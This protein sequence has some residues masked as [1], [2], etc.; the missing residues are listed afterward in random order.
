MSAINQTNKTLL[1]ESINPERINLLTL[2]GEVKDADSLSDEKIREI[3]SELEVSSFD[4]CIE[5]FVPMVYACYNANSQKILYSLTRP[6]NVPEHMLTEIPL[7]KHQD[8]MKMLLTLLETK[9]SAGMLNVD[10]KFEDLLK[11]ITP[12]KVMDDIKQVRADLQYTYSEYAKLEDGDPKKLDVADKLNVLFEQASD[13]YSN[14]LAMLPLAIEDTKMRLLMGASEMEDASAP[15]ALGVLTMGDDGELQVIEAPKVEST[16]LMTLDDHINEGLM[17]KLSEDY[18]AVCDHHSPYVQALATRTFCPLPSTVVQEVDIAQE[19]QN[20]N[21]YLEF[22]RDAKAGF[23]KIVKPLA[24]KLLGIKAYFDQ[25]PKKLKGGMKPKLLLT[26]CS[27]E[28]IAKSSNLPRL[29]AFLNSVNAKND[30]TN[31]IWYAIIPAI[32]L[33]PKAKVKLKRERFK[34]NEIVE[35]QHVNSIESL[36]RLMDVFK[37]YRIQC[38]FSFEGSEHTTFSHLAQNGV[39]G[40]IER[41]TLVADK[42]YSEF[43]IPCF[44]NFTIVP[45]DKSGVILDKRIQVNEAGAAVLSKEKEDIMR[46][47]VNGVYVGAAYVAAGLVATYQCPLYLRGVFK[48]KTHKSLPGV[49]FDIEQGNNSLRVTTTMAKEI[50]GFTTSIKDQINRRNF[51]FVFSSEN[52]AFESAAIGQ[53]MVYKARCLMTEDGVYA[54]IYKTQTTTYIERILRH[55]TSDFKAEN[56]K[57]FFSARPTSQK[58][59]WETAKEYVNGIMQI[60]DDIAYSIDEG[61]GICILDATFNGDSKNL[62]IEIKRHTPTAV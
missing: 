36:A 23:I 3:I 37:D 16:A 7:N 11:L 50:M 18:E 17:E 27:P 47:W 6:E 20:Y 46:L 44:P 4:E 33:D 12:A 28:M 15:L 42:H 32:S 22:Y 62:E 14:V 5:K 39:D 25:Y 40:F 10:F 45:K 30:Y 52:A 60:G 38:F 19:V 43:A 61:S 31:A 49:R 24:E 41:L 13:N 53:A 58:S 56:I 29:I 8:F 57:E 35:N 48:S 2:V 51:G 1:V 55:A 26:N 54:P 21:S 9:G 59:E 34:G